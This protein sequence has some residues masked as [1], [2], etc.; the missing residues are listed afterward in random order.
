MEPCLHWGPVQG[1]SKRTG[2]NPVHGR[3]V[4]PV[5]GRSAGRASS[6]QKFPR[7]C[8]NRCLEFVYMW[9]STRMAHTED[10]DLKNTSLTLN[11]NGGLSEEHVTS[12]SAA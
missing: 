6:P 9:P 12:P 4:G 2:S 1:V 10:I 8:P 3:S 5:H 7:S 11:P